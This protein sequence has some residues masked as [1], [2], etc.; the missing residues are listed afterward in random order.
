MKIAAAAIAAQIE[1]NCKAHLDGEIDRAIWGA[2]Q[3]RLWKLAADARMASDVIRL[4]APSL[5]VKNVP[6]YAI[7][8]QLR[9][10]ALAIGRMK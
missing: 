8:K 4:V 6:L 3:I 2:E 10:A 5:N 9:K 1:A 7:R